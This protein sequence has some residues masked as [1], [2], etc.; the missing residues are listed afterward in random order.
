MACGPS[1][2]RGKVGVIGLDR[3]EGRSTVIVLAVPSIVCAPVMRVLGLVLVIGLIIG[4]LLG[5]ML[6]ALARIAVG[7]LVVLVGRQA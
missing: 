1:H 7:G 3:S 2:L 5:H 4:A 6:A